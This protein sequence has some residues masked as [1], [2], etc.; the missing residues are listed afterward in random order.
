MKITITILAA[1]LAWTVN[2]APLTTVI[3]VR[4]AEKTAVENDPPL[5]SGGEARAGQLARM[6]GNSGIT[7][8]YTTPYARTRDTAAP[9]AAALRLT[10]IEVK[11]GPSYAAD[12]AAKIRAEHA[13]GTVLVVGHSNTTQNVMK[14]LGIE[15]AP[16]IEETEYD[17]L[18]IV[19]LTS[20]GAK[21]LVLK[22]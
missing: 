10:P 13:S 1:L 21:M 5:T 15:N 16:K 17:N 19:T 9:I 2:A 4:H 18:F 3:L 12:L 7:A 6:L 8:I 20:S 11:P 14:A 22:Y